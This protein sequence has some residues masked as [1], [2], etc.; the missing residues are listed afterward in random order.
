MEN[1]DPLLERVREAQTAVTAASRS[2]EDAVGSAR[3]AG[4]T[5]Q[6]IGTILGVTKQAASQRF[7]A[8]PVYNASSLDQIQKELQQIADEVFAALAHSDIERVHA[9]MTYAAARLLSKRKI[10]KVWNSVVDSV[11]PFIEVQR[12]VIEWTGSQYVLT[13][14]LRHDHGEPVGQIAFNKAKKI[15]GLV[16]YLDD[17][18]ELPW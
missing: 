10:F 15:T 12:S 1:S 4:A 17:S 8:T 5:W 2:L 11:G 6:Q 3:L 13:F 7:H 14:R 16:I 9:L 18:T